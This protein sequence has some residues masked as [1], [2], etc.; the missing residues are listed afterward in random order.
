LTNPP[1]A[2]EELLE[3][4]ARVAPHFSEMAFE[5]FKRRDSGS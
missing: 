5:A 2:L 3:R 1:L 4:L